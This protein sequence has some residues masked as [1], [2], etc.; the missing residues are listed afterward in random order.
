MLDFYAFL[1]SVCGWPWAAVNNAEERRFNNDTPLTCER[2]TEHSEDNVIK[3]IIQ[4]LTIWAASAAKMAA[5]LPI[6][7]TGL[8]SSWQTLGYFALSHGQV[9]TCSGCN[10]AGAKKS[11]EK[12]SR[13]SRIHRLYIF[14][15]H[16]V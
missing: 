6:L 1:L 15:E 5:S 8:F 12:Q 2:A 11:F 16:I 4:A 13:L 10:I 9:Q 3:L 14:E 7:S